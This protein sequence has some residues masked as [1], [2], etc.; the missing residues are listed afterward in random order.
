MIKR[1]YLKNMMNYKDGIVFDFTSKQEKQSNIVQQSF[2]HGAKTDYINGISVMYGKNNVGKSNFLRI[3]DQFIKTI[4]KKDLVELHSLIN[5]SDKLGECEIELLLENE[6]TEYEYYFSFKSIKGSI[7]IIDEK[8]MARSKGSSKQSLVYDRNEKKIG[9]SLKKDKRLIEKVLDL[10]A[11]DTPLLKTLSDFKINELDDF[12]NILNSICFVEASLE[13]DR[14]LPEFY[15]EIAKNQRCI[16]LINRF[17]TSVDMN[18]K[19]VRLNIFSDEETSLIN[20]VFRNTSANISESEQEN[21]K[22]AVYEII[23]SK[24]FPTLGIRETDENEESILSI[25][26]INNDNTEYNIAELST[27]TRN[28][29]IILLNLIYIYHN[30][31]MPA[32][33]LIDEIELGM[34]PHIAVSLVE[35]IQKIVEKNKN[36]QFIIATHQQEILDLDFI[37][38]YSKII[39][40]NSIEGTEINYVSDFNIRKEHVLSKRYLANAFGSGPEV[41]SIGEGN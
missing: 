12:Y 28:Y 16:D 9:Q 13:M 31:N 23:K 11:D 36:A 4:L 39:L 18:I 15:F 10:I 5:K 35:F 1:I 14:I 29:F 21:Q 40:S 3:I 26:F 27:G 8:L 37:S 17:I 24:G 25:T 19:E 32:I 2:V 38:K 33:V 20:N 22:K 6:N 7:N 41:T 34:H 30:S